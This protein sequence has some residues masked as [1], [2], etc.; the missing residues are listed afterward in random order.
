MVRRGRDRIAARLHEEVAQLERARFSLLLLQGAN[1]ERSAAE[2]ELLS[3]R[4][5]R[6]AGAFEAEAEA[7]AEVAVAAAALSRSPG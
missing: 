3:S 5:R 2:L 7:T 1:A 4:L 6:S